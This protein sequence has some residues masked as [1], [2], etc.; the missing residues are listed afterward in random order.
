VHRVD[1]IDDIVAMWD[2]GRARDAAWTNAEALW[3]IRDDAA[4]AQAYL[5]SLDR[6]V[7]FAGRGLLVP[8]DT[9]LQKL[10]RAFRL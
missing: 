7:G 8:A 4:L 1:R 10:G 6:M 3:A 5:D 2:V 9:W